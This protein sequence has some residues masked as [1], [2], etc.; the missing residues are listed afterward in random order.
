MR[1]YGIS[2][3]GLVRAENQDFFDVQEVCSNANLFVVCD[4]MGGSN[5]GKIASTIAC[6]AFCDSLLSKLSKCIARNRL[7]VKFRK[8]IPA[9][10][11][12]A[13]CDAN[14][15]V[16]D[17]ASRDCSLSGMGTTL[18]ATLIVDTTA[19]LIN[20]GDSR[21]YVSS[22]D[23]II[24][25]TKDHSYVQYLV[26][27]GKITEEEAYNH[28]QKNIITR[29]VGVD[30]EV[31][32][33]IYKMP[34]IA[35]QYVLLCTDGLSNAVSADEMCAILNNDISVQEKAQQLV[36]MAKDNDSSDNITALV[37]EFSK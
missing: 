7:L 8:N 31:K 16:F 36:Q 9:I 11:S 18:V 22:A 35:G 3:I 34:L 2:D 15:A 37:I 23:R 6:N 10:L 12:E 20:V 5:G 21:A 4:G 25:I 17:A 14:N 29:S 33:D 24:Q 26:D 28:P 13:L 27:M 19:F 1:Y 32:P 30:R